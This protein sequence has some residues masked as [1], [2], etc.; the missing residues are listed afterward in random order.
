MQRD[1]HGNVFLPLQNEI[2]QRLRFRFAERMN[3]G[4]G[5]GAD[6]DGTAAFAPLELKVAVDVRPPAFLLV[7][8]VVEAQFAQRHRTADLGQ[9]VRVVGSRLAPHAI[10]GVRVLVAVRIDHRNEKPVKLVQ[11]AVVLAG[12]LHQL[13]HHPRQ[14]GRRNPFVAVHALCVQSETQ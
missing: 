3:S 6:V 4:E 13:L 5:S 2:G 7:I 9:K 10:H 11:D 14:S 1:V 8:V 12:I